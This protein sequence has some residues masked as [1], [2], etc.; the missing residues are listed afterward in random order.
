M[1]RGGGRHTE[2]LAEGGAALGSRRSLNHSWHLRRGCGRHAEQLADGDAALGLGGGAV[3]GDGI[4]D[5][6]LELEDAGPVRGPVGHTPRDGRAQQGVVVVELVA[7]EVARVRPDRLGRPVRLGDGG[8][9]A[10]RGHVGQH[11][12]YLCGLCVSDGNHF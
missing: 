1:S 5:E 9:R 2:Q 4:G 10:R 3:D 12:R 7:D 6:A 11:P 8:L